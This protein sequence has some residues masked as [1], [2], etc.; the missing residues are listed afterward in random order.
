MGGVSHD[1]PTTMES[2]TSFNLLW[3]SFVTHLHLTQKEKN[4]IHESWM[5]VFPT[6]ITQSKYCANMMILLKQQ[7]LQFYTFTDGVFSGNDGTKEI[8][9]KEWVNVLYP[10]LTHTPVPPSIAEI[11]NQYIILVLTTQYSGIDSDETLTSL[12]V[13]DIPAVGDTEQL[14]YIASF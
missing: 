1:I 10:L 14:N 3:D 2:E 6:I 7:F 5:R 11:L 4:Q 13:L 9:Y 12:G 8:M